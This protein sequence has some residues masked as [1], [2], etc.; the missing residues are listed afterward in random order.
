MGIVSLQFTG[1]A[2]FRRFI[3][4]LFAAW[5]I[6]PRLRQSLLAQRERNGVSIKNS[7]NKACWLLCVVL[8][9]LWSWQPA[10][11]AVDECAHTFDRSEM[12]LFSFRRL[13]CTD[14]GWSVAR[15]QGNAEA[16]CA[17][18]DPS[19]RMIV[20]LDSNGTSVVMLRNLG[21][22]TWLTTADQF[23]K[24][25]VEV[26]GLRLLSGLMQV[27]VSSS[28]PLRYGFLWPLP[29]DNIGLLKSGHAL[30]VTIGKGHWNIRLAGS[31]AAIAATQSCASEPPSE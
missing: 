26:D 29:K 22:P 11:A 1:L 12:S 24:V 8:P 10:K 16:Q 28:P 9:F 13:R 5:S 6:F 4:L 20:V 14:E 21:D 17:A 15:R 19:D 3:N 31:Q 30:S 25:K 18:L 7:L 23:G 2:T 27:N